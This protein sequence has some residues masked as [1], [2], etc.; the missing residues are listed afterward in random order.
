MKVRRTLVVTILGVVIAAPA[1]LS[2]ASAQEPTTQVVYGRST[3]SSDR[4]KATE[5]FVM[6]VD[7]TNA[8]QLTNNDKEDAFPVLSPDGSR[9]AFARRIRG[10]FDLFVMDSDGDNPARLTRTRNADEVLPSWSPD[11]KKLAFTATVPIPGGWQSDIY[12]MRVSNGRFRR[13]TYTPVAKEFAPDW[14][15]DGTTIAF[16]KQDQRRDRYG[17]ATVGPDAT[18]LDWLVINPDSG[19]GYTDVNPS[20]SPDSQWIAFSRDHGADPYVDIFKV[21][22]DGSELTPVTQLNELAE[23]PVWGSDDR[24]LFMHNEGIAIVPS[25]GGSIEHI[26]PTR[27]GIPYWWPDW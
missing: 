10:Q 25:A 6:D 27:T 1:L 2:G 14:S 19:A 24:I 5:I 21:R 12:R 17:I 11:G 7:G 3:A 4:P 26:T 9:I 18:E 13:L 20:W 16:T 23:N 15:P 8:T 22:R